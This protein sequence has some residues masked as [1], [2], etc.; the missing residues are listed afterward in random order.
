MMYYDDHN[1]PHF[2]VKY[3]E[4]NAIMNIE[5]LEFIKGD[6]PKRATAMVLEWANLNRSELKKNWQRIENHE[7]LKT[8]R[9]LDE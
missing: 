8:I 3:N 1:P 9:P 2:H 4:Y 7:A 6:L 5:T